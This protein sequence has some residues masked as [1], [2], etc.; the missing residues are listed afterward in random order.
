MSEH[1]NEDMEEDYILDEAQE[2]ANVNAGEGAAA[3]IEAEARARADAAH[4]NAHLLKKERDF[5]IPGEKLVE[6]MD[7]LPGRNCFRE[8][9]GIYSKKIGLLSV[10]GRVL[11]VIPLNGVYMPVRGDM[12]IGE[13]TDIQGNGWVIN[14]KAPYDAY[15]PLSGV[16]GFIDTNKTDISKIYDVGEIVYG[17]IN[18]VTASKSIHISMFDRICRKFA[19]GRV[20]TVNPAKVPRII[21]RNGSMIDLIKR[22]TDT[23]VVVGQNGLVW[24]EGER[25][26][27]VIDVI[28]FIEEKSHMEGLTNEVEKILERGVVHEKK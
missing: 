17:K 15:L 26:A 20:I 6:S 14:I 1:M 21:G 16:R 23:R 4:A 27:F 8:G 12:V 18:M 11:S 9:N 28:R 3:D 22:K 7:F 13:V 10:E 5:V 25:E 24:L 2:G 19:G